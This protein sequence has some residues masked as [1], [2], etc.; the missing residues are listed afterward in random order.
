MTNSR[1]S[2]LHRAGGE[3]GQGKCRRGRGQ[4]GRT[5]LAG[6]GLQRL[7]EALLISSFVLSS[8][9]P[10]R[11]LGWGTGALGLQRSSCRFM[12]SKSP[13]LGCQSEGEAS[14]GI[15]SMALTQTY[16]CASVAGAGGPSQPGS[17]TGPLPAAPLESCH[18]RSRLDESQEPRG[19]CPVGPGRAPSP[20][21]LSC[22]AGGKRGLV[23]PHF[24][25]WH[26]VKPWAGTTP[27]LLF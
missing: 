8:G 7:T 21:G 2:V 19:R 26:P 1:H 20:S 17:P 4:A 9:G 18:L 10:S 14:E 13:K 6:Q 11:A 27:A 5:G 22:S 15:A 12:V 3:A 16:A 23:S 24:G 25:R